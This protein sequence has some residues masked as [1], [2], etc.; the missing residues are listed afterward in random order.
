MSNKT[1]NNP[2][3][4]V[5][6]LPLPQSHKR[7]LTALVALLSIAMLSSGALIAAAQRNPGKTELV[8]TQRATWSGTVYTD[9]Y[10]MMIHDDGSIHLLIGIGKFG[11]ADRVAPFN[12]KRCQVDGWALAR[13]NRSAIQLDITQDAIREST[14]AIRP[15]P[16]QT[17]QSNEPVELIGEIV[18]GKCFLGAMKPGDGKAHK[19]CATLCIQG[20]LPPMF[21][22]SDQSPTTQLPLVLINGSPTLPQSV[23]ELVGEPIKLTA[24]RSTLGTLEILSIDPQSLQRWTNQKP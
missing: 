11:V 5:G 18:D 17:A 10:P 20:G 21:A 6:Y 13:T 19:A 7:F 2:E 22:A 14:G 9:P 12:G 8:S 23:L 24:T 1:S 3:F 4:Y 16:T 15:A